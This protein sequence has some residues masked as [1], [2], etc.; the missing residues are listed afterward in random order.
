MTKQKAIGYVLTLACQGVKDE[1]VR[2]HLVGL[3]QAHLRAG[4]PAPNW[5]EMARLGQIRKGLTRN[6][7][8][9][10]GNGL[11]RDPVRWHHLEAMKSVWKQCGNKRHDAMGSRLF[12]LLWL[13][14]AG[15]A[16]APESG[17]FDPKAHLC[18][19]DVMDV[20]P[21]ANLRHTHAKLRIQVLENE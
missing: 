7:A 10:G 3:R 4:L 18:W 13:L 12:V 19:E 14:R 8:I 15:E 11:V 1:T 6:R 16:L 17:S 21:T 20:R 9:Q 5:R 2:H